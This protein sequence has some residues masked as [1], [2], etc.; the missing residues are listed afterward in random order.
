MSQPFRI[1]I[2]GGGTGGHIY[3]AIAI[4]QA[5]KA[6]NPNTDIHFVGSTRGLES[7]I[8][9]KAGFPLHLIKVGRLNNNVSLFERIKTLVFMP[10][11]FLQCL[12]IVFKIKPERIF[13]CTDD[14]KC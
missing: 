10:F 5:I 7:Q 13:R 6:S 9:P 3:P 11:S 14:F 8:V 1:V 4:A 12:W 2:A